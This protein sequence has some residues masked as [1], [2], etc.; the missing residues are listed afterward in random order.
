[1]LALIGRAAPPATLSPIPLREIALEAPIPR[2]RRN[3]FCVG[4]NYHEHA[5]EFASS[6]FNSSAAAGVVPKHP[7]I[8]S[9]V[10]ETRR[11]A[12]RFRAHRSQA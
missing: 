9:K 8:F 10:P 7:I 5:K 1:M 4:K 3:M 6:G 12:S 2:P 11:G